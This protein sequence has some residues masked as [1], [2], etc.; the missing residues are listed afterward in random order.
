MLKILQ[1]LLG[2]DFRS[3]GLRR[4]ILRSGLFD[5]TFY[6]SR[7]PGVMTAGTSALDHFVAIGLNADYQPS[8]D[9]DP[10]IYR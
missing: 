10:Q 3:F 4:T 8:A 2:K 7:Y 9:F 1:G 6:L 5:E